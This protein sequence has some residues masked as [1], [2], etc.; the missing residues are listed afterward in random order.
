MVKAISVA[1]IA[2]L[3]KIDNRIFGM[4][5]IQRP[6]I[7]S[8]LVGILYQDIQTG[9]LLGAQIELLSMG[10]VGIGAHSG[11]PDITIGSALCTAFALETGS[12]VEVALA[13]AL[14]I[15]TFALMIGYLTWIPL[16]H[17]LS[18]QSKKAA[19]MGDIKIME[20][21]QWLG[22]FNYFFFPFIVVLVGMFAGVPVFEYLIEVIPS[23][24]TEGIQVATGMLP[25]LGF[26]LL[27]Q[28]TFSWSMAAYLF[29]G[30]VI[31]AFFGLGNVGVA[32]IGAILASF[33]FASKDHDG[34]I[35]VE[36]D[37]I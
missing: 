24:I 18:E 15:S 8:T 36:S 11:M 30:F 22:L 19:S 10:L 27:M 28:L 26:A 14:P 33:A 4:T 1:L 25:A 37:E 6:L 3:G 13:L 12:G 16:N 29:I 35:G 17:I 23:W 2:G 5:M 9:L 20:R 34:E 32:I 7:I 21:N 31:V